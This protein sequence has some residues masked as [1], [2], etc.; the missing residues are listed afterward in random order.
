MGDFQPLRI[1]DA[2][3]LHHWLTLRLNLCVVTTLHVDGWP[4]DTP[5]TKREDRTFMRLLLLVSPPC[6]G[7]GCFEGLSCKERMAHMGAP[8]NP[9][10]VRQPV[11]MSCFPPLP[12]SILKWTYGWSNHCKNHG[13]NSQS[14]VQFEILRS[15]K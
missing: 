2:S 5:C 14:Q 12:S 11:I 6:V 13:S 1:T 9:H 15:I 3:R 8:C 7:G 10:K 4:S